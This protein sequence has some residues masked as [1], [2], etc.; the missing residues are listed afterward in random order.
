VPIDPN[1][2]TLCCIPL[3]YAV[4]VIGL[5]TLVSCFLYIMLIDRFDVHIA[6]QVTPIIIYIYLTALFVN[7]NCKPKRS[8]ARKAL[9]ISYLFM[10][11]AEEAFFVY[12]SVS[13]IGSYTLYY[14]VKQTCGSMQSQSVWTEEPTETKK[15]NDLERCIGSKDQRSEESAWIVVAFMIMIP[16]KVYFTFVLYRYWLDA[17]IEERRELEKISARLS[18]P[19]DTDDEAANR[20]NSAP[21][22]RLEADVRK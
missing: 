21:M 10:T 13:Y 16:L 14:F 5:F 12:Q 6:L 15:A 3:Q 11:L 9:Y 17:K 4:L 19:D 8:L 20:A 7:A 1:K 2:V 18:K 22:S